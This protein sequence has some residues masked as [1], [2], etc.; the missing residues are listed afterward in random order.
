MAIQLQH[1][2]VLAGQPGS[3]NFLSTIFEITQFTPGQLS[4]ELIPRFGDETYIAGSI[5]RYLMAARKTRVVSGMLYDHGEKDSIHEPVVTTGSSA[6]AAGATVAMTVNAAYMYSAPTSARAPYIVTGTAVNSSP[7][8]DNDILICPNGVLGKVTGT[9]RNNPT[10]FNLTPLVSGTNIPAI[11][12]TDLLVN[13]GN[14][15]GERTGKGD[16][17]NLRWLNVRNNIQ[18]SKWIQSDS[19]ASLGEESWFKVAGMDGQLENRWTTQAIRDMKDRALNEVE[20]ML[21][22]MDNTTNTTLA[23]IAGQSTA[24]TTKG[25]APAIDDYGTAE[26]Y[27]ITAMD[28]TDFENMAFE[29]ASY[30]GIS[31]SMAWC[32]RRAKAEADNALRGLNGLTN[33]GVVYAVPD[34]KDIN[35]MFDSVKIAGVKYKFGVLT[36]LDS[37]FALGATGQQTQNVI[38]FVPNDDRIAHIGGKEVT[39]PSMAYVYQNIKNEYMGWR[40]TITGG[41]GAGNTSQVDEQE[42]G[43]SCRF[44]YEFFAL[45]RYG[46]LQGVAA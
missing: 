11:T 26:N 22:I 19:G 9:V 16:S 24:V 21:L 20:M 36:A 5:S 44:G 42:Y 41:A 45:N 25:L 30:G 6:G 32:S 18:M 12:N 27:T 23:N 31:E 17:R 10:T 4:N 28:I 43:V 38:Y 3:H 1:P 29:Q 15:W 8:Q 34:A 37:P 33:G 7:I 39:V 40:E 13:V 35:L 2:Q 14:S 46:K